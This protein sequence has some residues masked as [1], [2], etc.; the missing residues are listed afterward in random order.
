MGSAEIAIAKLLENE[1]IVEE[2]KAR[3]NARLTELLNDDGEACKDGALS[4]YLILM[5]RN[6]RNMQEVHVSMLELLEDEHVTGGCVPSAQRPAPR[7]APLSTPLPFPH[8]SFPPTC[9]GAGG[10][11][12]AHAG[13]AQGQQ[14]QRWRWR[15]GQQGSPHGCPRGCLPHL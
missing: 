13:S 12:A 11:A 9:R 14:Q 1:G 5:L 7:V 8:S 6:K 3:T 4:S 10:L 2:L 15:R